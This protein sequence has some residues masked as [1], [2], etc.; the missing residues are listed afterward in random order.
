MLVFTTDKKRLLEHFQKDPVLF[1]Y[2]I[3]DLDDFYFPYCQWAATYGKSPRIDDILLLYTGCETPTLLAFGLTDK[4]PDLLSDFL[5]LAPSRFYGH[6]LAPHRGVLQRFADETPLGA[7][8]KM[9]LDVDRFE[10]SDRRERGS[11]AIFRLDR[12]RE[13]E[14]RELYAAAYPDNYFVPRML[15]TGK[16][17]GYREGGRLV[18]V[19]GVH[20]DSDEQKI[21]VL[22][23]I[24]TYPD[25]RGRGLA[26][27]LTAHLL[28][29]L[30]AESKLVSLNVKADNTPAIACYKRLGFE[31]VREYE[32]GLFTLRN[33]Q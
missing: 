12:S 7:H 31:T 14:L 8:L 21:A 20:V 23:N 27:R 2:H 17:F 26:G 30:V 32:E 1:A 22:G 18:A 3:G 6:F 13:P 33:S 16:Y 10:S 29:E 5:P 19:T 4:F 11:A 15:E 25:F 9:R 28:R 24:A